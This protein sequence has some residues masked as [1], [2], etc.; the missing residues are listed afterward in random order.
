MLR[1][2]WFELFS[3]I[4]EIKTE[5]SYRSFNAADTAG[6]EFTPFARRDLLRAPGQGAY[7]S[8]SIPKLEGKGNKGAAVTLDGDRAFGQVAAHE[9]MALGI[10]KAHQHGIAAVALHNSHHI[11]RI[12]NSYWAN[13]VA[14]GGGLISRAICAAVR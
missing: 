2:Y 1:R 6:A 7:R 10:E 9:A 4:S 5:I 11:G 8:P 12:G 3:S 13:G 14:A